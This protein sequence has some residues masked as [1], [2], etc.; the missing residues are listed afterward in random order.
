[1]DY[2]TALARLVKRTT[3]ADTGRRL[4]VSE[5]TVRRWLTGQTRPYAYLARLIVLEDAYS[6]GEL[7]ALDTSGAWRGW[8]V[9]ADGLLYDP[10]GNAY[11][12]GDITACGFIRLNGGA[13]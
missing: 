5:R 10:A 4:G 1:M 3:A 13:R 11:S 7:A 2:H 8:R 6:F 9:A 12:P